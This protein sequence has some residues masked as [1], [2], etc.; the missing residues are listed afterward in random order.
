MEKEK[1]E[2]IESVIFKFEKIGDELKGKYIASE[3][4]KNYGNKVYKIETDDGVMAVFGTV[5]LESKMD[6]INLGDS[7]KI[8]FDSVKKNPKKGQN[9]IKMFKVFRERH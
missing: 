6:N 5:V 4:G 9:D 7:I 1:Y 8:V 2:E 3:I